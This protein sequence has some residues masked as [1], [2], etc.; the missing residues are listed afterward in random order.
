MIEVVDIRGAVMDRWV[1]RTGASGHLVKRDLRHLAAGK[2]LLRV[3]DRSGQVSERSEV[4][5]ITR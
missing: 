3:Q 1:E 2:Y 4:L 5:I